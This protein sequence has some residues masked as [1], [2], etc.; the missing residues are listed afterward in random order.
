MPALDPIYAQTVALFIAF[1]FA[2]AGSHKLMAYSRHAGIVA[3]YQ[4]VPASLVPVLAPLVLIRN[5]RRSGQALAVRVRVQKEMV[6]P[7]M[8][9]TTG[10]TS[11]LLMASCPGPSPAAS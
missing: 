2:F 6:C 3:D 1:V 4:I 11:Q 5:S 10:E 8:R 9:S 7:S